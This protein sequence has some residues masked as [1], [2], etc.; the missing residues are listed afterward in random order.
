MMC[1]VFV[2]VICNVVFIVIVFLFF[3]KFIVLIFI[4]FSVVFGGMVILFYGVIVSNGLK[5]LIENCVN[6][7]EVCNLIIVS[8]ML[9]L[10]F[11]GVV[12]DLGV[13]ILLGI[14]LSVIVGIILNLILLKESMKL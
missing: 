1:I 4:I 10:G 2:M 6:F 3:G 13:L 12:F 7:V 5:V 8:F 14:V 11:G 9:V